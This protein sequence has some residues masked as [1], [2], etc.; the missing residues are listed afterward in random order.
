MRINISYDS[1]HREKQDHLIR[2]NIRGRTGGKSRGFKHQLQPQPHRSSL[3]SILFADVQALD[4]KL[5]DL[6]VYM[7]F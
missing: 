1:N 4:N 7:S 5:D 6:P 2:L 3:L